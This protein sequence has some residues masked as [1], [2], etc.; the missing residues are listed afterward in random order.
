MTTKQ[1]KEKVIL[2]PEV[3]SDQYVCAEVC[4]EYKHL[5]LADKI[6]MDI[7]ANIGAFAV[8]ATLNGAKQVICYEPETQNFTQLKLNC[9]KYSN[10]IQHQAAIV[11]GEN[12]VIDFYLT[13][14]KAKDGYSIIPFKGRTVVQCQ[15]FN[16]HE[17]LEL[18][19]P[20]SIKMDV[21]G[22]EF[23]LLAKPL[24]DFVK[25]IVVE[26]HFNKRVFRERFDDLIKNFA[27]WDCVIKPKQ[28]G[29]NFHT[30]AQYNRK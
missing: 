12:Q 2:R 9:S 19:K 17:Q 13:N 14:G 22:A 15:A 30:L 10:V 29:T 11:D 20:E 23:E 8:Y 4:G 7:G 6:V 24:P 18:H 16:F 21:E 25:S 27:D 5:P 3:T 26:I 28:T 1:L